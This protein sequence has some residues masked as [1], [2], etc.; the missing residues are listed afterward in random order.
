M[1][2]DIYHGEHGGVT[3]DTEKDFL[4]RQQCLGGTQRAAAACCRWILRRLFFR[5]NKWL[6]SVSSVF[7]VV[8]FFSVVNPMSWPPV[9]MRNEFS[10]NKS[11]YTPFY[12][13]F[14]VS[15]VVCFYL[16]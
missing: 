1:R 7:S 14:S 9:A 2:K 11:A 8:C 13:Q 10:P 16:W 12:K 5:M 6:F 4:I 15:S 3:E